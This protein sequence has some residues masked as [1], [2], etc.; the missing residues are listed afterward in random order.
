MGILS[1][2]SVSV[3]IRLNDL[4]QI[5]AIDS[6]V[7]IETSQRYIHCLPLSQSSALTLTL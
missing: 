7:P 1:C 4:V 2:Q 6:L 3:D 5:L